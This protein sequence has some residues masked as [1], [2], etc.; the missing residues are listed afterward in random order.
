MRV[1]HC[2]SGRVTNVRFHDIRVEDSRKLISLWIGKA[3]WSKSL[4][5][6]HIRGVTFE[7]IRATAHPGF[8]ELHGFDAAHLVEDVTFRH[9]VINGKPLTPR[10]VSANAYVKAVQ[11]LRY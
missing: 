1:Y 11:V 7:N 5:R 8:V 9:V 6:G 2:D 10:H 4:N 3:Q